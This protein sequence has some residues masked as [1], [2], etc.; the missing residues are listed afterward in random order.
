MNIHKV[1]FALYPNNAINNMLRNAIIKTHV[2]DRDNK[3]NEINRRYNS[4][5]NELNDAAVF[6]EITVMRNGHITK[7]TSRAKDI[8][9]TY[10]KPK[11]IYDVAPDKTGTVI[12]PNIISGCVRY[13]DVYSNGIEVGCA[14]AFT[15]IQSV[16]IREVKEESYER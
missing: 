11:M 9:I 4:M 15:R 3:I 2:N 13:T 16:H 8:E 14:V 7:L 12:Y 6:R 5:V 10:D 1:A